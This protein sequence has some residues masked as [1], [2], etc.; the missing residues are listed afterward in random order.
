MDG[1]NS[2]PLTSHYHLGPTLARV[3]NYHH[4]LLG[5]GGWGGIVCK[6]KIRSDQK[7][8]VLERVFCSMCQILG[9]EGGGKK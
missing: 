6:L 9:V 7:C 5:L 4:Y 1:S 8:W 2:E 3:W